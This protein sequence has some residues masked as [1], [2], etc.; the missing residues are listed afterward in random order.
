L[1]QPFPSQQQASL[2]IHDQPSTSTQSYVLMCTG[3]SKK[4]NVALTT[5]AKDYTPS[6]EKVDD[7][8]PDLVQP[9]PPNP[10]T[11]GPLH[12][13]RPSLDTVLRPLKGVV[14]KSAFNPHARA[15]QNYSIVE[16]LAQAPSAMSALEV[17]QSCP[18]QRR[19]LL[20][21][22]GGID[23]TDTNLI[24]FDLEDHVPRL[25]PQLAFQIQV[26]V[27]DKSICR[28]VIDE[29]ASTC[30]MSFTCWKAIG[31]PPLSESQNTLR[32]F[33]GSGFK[34]YDVLP[35]LPVTLEGKTVQ[36]EVEVFDTPLDYNLLLGRSW[37]DSM[38]VVVSTLFRVVRF[39]HQGKVVTVDQLAFFNT[40]T[41]TGNVSFIAKTPQG[42][43]NVG[44]GLLKYSSLMGTFP[45]P[46]PP[47]IPRPS[48]HLLI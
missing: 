43:E 13:E 28:T 21:A 26:V 8:P 7:L 22:I 47:D 42:Y 45:I 38:R 18:A 15:A 6:K 32:A 12:L 9:S 30:V 19:A 3:D 35:A 14:K 24:V 33:N 39:P 44:V 48:L 29:G 1:S 16:D 40:D 41:R 36:V 37:V 10:P 17:L 31:S 34:P 46:P 23:P 20:K 11:N 27:A 2:V 25:P 4:D 5:R